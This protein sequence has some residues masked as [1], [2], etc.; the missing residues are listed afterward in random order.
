MHDM[1][2]GLVSVLVLDVAQRR[3]AFLADV[4][5]EIHPAALP[6]PLP[7]APDVVEG[8]L[9]VRGEV[10]PVIDLRR[11]LGLPSRSVELTDCLVVMR[12]S[13]RRLAVRVDEAV[14]LADVDRTE[15]TLDSRLA[16]AAYTA[17]TAA[18]DGGLLVVLDVTRF[19][20]EGEADALQSA[21]E[22]RR[23]GV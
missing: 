9:D 18:H 3:I 2:S 1:S 11:R 17:A 19:L 22:L 14:T 16:G 12:A 4:V 8:V 23:A 15:L 7:G 10:V 21:L 20:T 6:T 5:D 13:G